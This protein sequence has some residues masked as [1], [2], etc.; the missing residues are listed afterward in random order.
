VDNRPRGGAR[1]TNP[2]FGTENLERV[3]PLLGTL[4]E[5]ADAHD[6]KPAQV[7]LAWLV[8]LP[9]VVVIPGASGVEQVESN[10]AAAEIDLA[11]DE[12]AALTAAARA[13]TP[14]S[15]VRTIADGVRERIE[16]RRARARSR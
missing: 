14:V 10:A 6:A 11:D 2:L 1:A 3:A 15:T 4:R 8:A 7:A 5:V 12:R 9:R 13:F 16:G